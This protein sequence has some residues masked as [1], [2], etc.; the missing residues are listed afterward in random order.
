MKGTNTLKISEAT[1]IEALQMMVD[2]TFAAPA[3][4]VVSAVVESEGSSRNGYK[5]GCELTLTLEAEVQ[6]DQPA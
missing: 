1:T 3:P 5:T 6:P 4:K 2:K